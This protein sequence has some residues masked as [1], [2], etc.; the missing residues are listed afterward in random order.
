MTKWQQPRRNVGV[1]D[2]VILQ[3]DNVVP[4]KWPLARIVEVHPGRD[5]LVRVVTVKTSNGIYKRPVSKIALLLP[6]QD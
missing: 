3:E 6:S 2:V 4:A 1:G 5:K